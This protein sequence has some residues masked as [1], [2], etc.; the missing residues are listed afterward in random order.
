MS[1]STGEHFEFQWINRR[2]NTTSKDEIVNPLPFGQLKGSICIEGTPLPLTANIY[3][4]LANGSCGFLVI[5][6][7]ICKSFRHESIRNIIRDAEREIGEES[8]L[9]ATFDQWAGAPQLEDAAYP[10]S[11]I[12]QHILSKRQGWAAARTF[13]DLTAVERSR[14]KKVVEDRDSGFQFSA[15]PAVRNVEERALL[16]LHGDTQFEDS[17][18][19][20]LQ[21]MFRSTLGFVFLEEEYVMSD[22]GAHDPARSC[23][24]HQAANDLLGTETKLI[25][26]AHWARPRGHPY[27]NHFNCVMLPGICTSPLVPRKSLLPAAAQAA[28]TKGDILPSEPHAM[29]SGPPAD[30]A[31]PQ[32]QTNSTSR[33]GLD[34]PT[35][36][37]QME[38]DVLISGT[39]NSG[40]V[41]DLHREIRM[42]VERHLNVIAKEGIAFCPGFGTKA[43][44]LTCCIR[45]HKPALKRSTLDVLRKHINTII[46]KVA[47]C[48][49]K[50]TSA[51]ALTEKQFTSFVVAV[52]EFIPNG[53]VWVNRP[54]A[55]AGPCAAAQRAAS[56]AGCGPGTEPAAEWGAGRGE[57]SPPVVVPSPPGPSAETAPPRTLPA[58]AGLVPRT[59]D[60][61]YPFWAKLNAVPCGLSTGYAGVICGCPGGSLRPCREP[62]TRP[63]SQAKGPVAFAG[64]GGDAASDELPGAGCIANTTSDC[65]GT[66][67]LLSTPGVSAIHP[68]V[69][70]PAHDVSR[71]PR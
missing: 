14:L 38:F 43:L 29:A 4:A 40:K 58:A 9:Y 69:Y 44:H 3:H 21:D 16:V 35:S 70:D 17:H 41:T 7:S 52:P 64:S 68:C 71:T 27:E 24:L 61:G 48:A 19:T 63:T 10:R 51:S 67:A 6:D 42:S 34:E 46:Q 49:L 59:K 25:L 45:R 53:V 62:L 57:G 60:A 36:L 18:L 50:A 65:R 56:E 26:F 23:F 31:L 47:G 12:S 1:A 13:L 55:G 11:F 33:G 20:V 54:P 37:L 66:A 2:K 22:S 39:I 15:D 30:C 32:H 8:R 5:H 28:P